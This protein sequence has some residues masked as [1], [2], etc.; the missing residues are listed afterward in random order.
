MGA[1]R[2]KAPIPAVLS[3]GYCCVVTLDGET[4]HELAAAEVWPALRSLV[5]SGS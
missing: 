4:H 1:E 3:V 5:E 2:S